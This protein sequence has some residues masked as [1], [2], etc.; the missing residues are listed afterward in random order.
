MTKTTF[1]TVLL[2]NMT[3]G[4]EVLPPG[5][6]AP[7]MVDPFSSRAEAEQWI[8]ERLRLKDIPPDAVNKAP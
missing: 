6:V 7:Y 1:K 5:R 2:E 8:G 4:V 3:F